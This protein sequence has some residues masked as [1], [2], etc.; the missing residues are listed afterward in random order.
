M[1]DWNVTSYEYT[2]FYTMKII[3]W[4]LSTYYI[5]LSGTSPQGQCSKHNNKVTEQGIDSIKIKTFLRSIQWNH[6]PQVGSTKNLK[7]KAGGGNVKVYFCFLG[8]HDGN[9]GTAAHVNLLSGGNIEV[10]FFVFWVIM[11]AMFRQQ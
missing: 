5:S 4:T 6:F 2:Y 3:I 1:F 9:F 8:D 10:Y 11:I 7:H